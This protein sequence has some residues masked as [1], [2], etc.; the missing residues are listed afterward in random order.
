MQENREHSLIIIGGGVAGLTAGCYASMNGYQTTILEMAAGPGGLCTSWR[1]KGYLF[2]GSVAGLAGSAPGSPLYRLWQE[3]GVAKYCPLHY[4]EDFGAIRLPDGRV[5]T[6]FTD[7]ER[8]EAHL[9]ENFPGDARAVRQFTRALRSFVDL[10]IPFSDA[11]GWAAVR[12]GVQTFFS[13]LRHL[14]ALMRYGTMT[15]RQFS[16]KFKD[17]A[18]VTA[19]N[20]F[21]HFGGPDVPL[22]TLLLPIAY[23]HRKMAGIP[24]HGWLSFARAVE[25]RFTELGGQIEYNTKVERVIVEEGV[26]QGV[27]LADGSRRLAGRVLSAADGRFSQSLLLGKPEGDTLQSFDPQEMSDQ[28]VQVN[29]GVNEDFSGETG[30]LTYILP[31]EQTAA[32]RSHARITVHNKCYDPDSAPAGKSALTVFLD[33]DYLWWKE[34]AAD[35]ER[36]KAE[37][38]RCAGMVI[39]ILESHRPGFRERVEVVDVSTPL[40]RERYTGNYMGTM[41]ARKPGSSIVTSLLKGGPQYAFQG[42][43]GL[44]MAGQWVEAW[45]GITT[46]AQSARKAVQAMCRKD[47]KSFTSSIA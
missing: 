19:F 43:E 17:P 42:I 29:L 18:L 37:K 39:D 21:V 23:A 12:E 47:G 34:V 31:K 11:R 45:G 16:G 4:G 3:I 13:M 41:Q 9:V 36:Y 22:I 24:Q 8:L 6:V 25:R 30:S 2:D 46:A 7:I 28:P 14:P 40:T 32:G 26:V 15:I 1:R 10:D 44:Y 5:I 33:S 35:P 27:L 20:N 38:E